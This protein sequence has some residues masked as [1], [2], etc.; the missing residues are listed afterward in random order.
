M[1]DLIPVLIGSEGLFA[2][3]S[4]ILGDGNE[5]II[6]RSRQCVISLQ[7]APR[8]LNMTED[9]RKALSHFSSVSRQHLKITIKGWKALLQNMSN[10]G[11]WCDDKRF[12][13]ELEV[14]MSTKPINLRLC[15]GESFNLLLI[16]KDESEVSL[17]ST[18]G[19]VCD[20]NRPTDRVDKPD[21]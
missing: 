4:F 1:S 11:T 8:Y 17:Q 2:G 13:G 12:D 7:K 21:A 19:L 14:E 6:G 15:P 10:F 16:K 3:E 20:A 9:E 5:V 18:R